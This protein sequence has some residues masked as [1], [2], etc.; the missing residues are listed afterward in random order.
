MTWHPFK[1]M[2]DYGGFIHFDKNG[3]LVSYSLRGYALYWRKDGLPL[4]KT[5]L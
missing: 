1:T 4:W 5:T 2:I 3:I